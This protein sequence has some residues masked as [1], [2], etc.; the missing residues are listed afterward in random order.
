MGGGAARRKTHLPVAIVAGLAVGVLAGILVLRAGGGAPAD[1]VADEADHEPTDPRVALAADAAPA[2]DEAEPQ[3]ALA[4][5]HDAG[6]LAPP[7]AAPP[8]AAAPAEEDEDEE[9]LGPRTVTLRFDVRPEDATGVEITV[10]GQAVSGR[11]HAIEVEGRG[12]R[13]RVVAR[14]RGFLTW[15]RNVAVGRDR[16]LRIELERFI[17]LDE[18]PGGLI[19]L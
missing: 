16:W 8:D 17:P 3:V 1:L 6:P 18:G 12:R 19:D 4:P 14:A 7:D 2:A 13:V 10:D 9:E 5:G 11:A 15:S